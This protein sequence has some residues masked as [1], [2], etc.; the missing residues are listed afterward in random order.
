M[1]SELQWV[2]RQLE[3]TYDSLRWV[4]A[5]IPDERLWWRPAPT[6]PA[7][8]WIVQHIAGAITVYGNVMLAGRRGPRQEIEEGLERGALM[9]RVDLSLKEARAV[10]ER[11]LPETLHAA[12]SDGW[13]PM[14]PRVEGPLDA[15]WFAQQM[16][17][18]TA[19]HVGQLNY[20]SRIL[21]GE[22]AVEQP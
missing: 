6:A 14:G 10:F 22:G 15:L 1:L 18:H 13:A 9:D 2:Y 21:E 4:M 17:R 11:V 20:I 5:E 19:Y 12:C 3:E 7:A 16:V 8:G